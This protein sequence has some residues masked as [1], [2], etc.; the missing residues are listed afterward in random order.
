MPDNIGKWGEVDL[1]VVG[2]HPGGAWLLSELPDLFPSTFKL[3]WLKEERPRSPIYVPP[4]AVQ[5]FKLHNVQPVA[6]E[7]LW[8]N[9]GMAW[10]PEEVALR[11]PKLS[12]SALLNSGVISFTA[13]QW[14]RGV[15]ETRA[16]E[17]IANVA[18]VHPELLGFADAF[19]KIFGKSHSVQWETRLWNL[20][21]CFDLGEWDPESQVPTHTERF[22]TSRLSRDIES[23]RQTSDGL[24][25]VKVSG[26]GTLHAKYLVL[27]LGLSDLGRLDKAIQLGRVP[28]EEVARGTPE[29]GLYPFG[30]ELEKAAVPAPMRPL[31]FLLDSVDIPEPSTEI[32]PIERRQGEHST[33]LKF[34]ITGEREVCLDQLSDRFKQAV[35]RMNQLL[36][37]AA[38]HIQRFTP[39]L[40]WNECAPDEKRAE[41]LDALE[42]DFSERYAFSLMEPRTRWKT[43][44]FVGP[45][46]FTQWPYPFGELRGAQI[47]KTL[48]TPSKKS[49]SQGASKVALPPSA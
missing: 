20:F 1:L 7:L 10:T 28:W 12:V 49:V 32:W 36:P 26:K 8:P 25:E 23:L 3:G 30:I 17:Q 40:E 44:F 16:R 31:T 42:G 38:R 41:A 6:S 37:F 22:Q 27:A 34:W 46:F 19:W 24:W 4:A 5:T 47:V 15:L 45:Y 9:D 21:N 14:S 11:F 13:N 48:L 43:L 18:R 35:R 33:Q 39:G 29:L 2:N